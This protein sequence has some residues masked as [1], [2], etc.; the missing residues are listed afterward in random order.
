MVG[1]V[2]E[3]GVIKHT[4]GFISMMGVDISLGALG[5]GWSVGDGGVAECTG[6]GA[7]PNDNIGVFQVRVLA[8]GLWLVESKLGRCGCGC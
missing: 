5:T 3:G 1:H 7:V 4:T 8:V 2:V 6:R